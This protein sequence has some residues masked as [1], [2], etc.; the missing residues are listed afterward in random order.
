M[1]ANRH[2]ETGGPVPPSAVQS[3]SSLKL[4]LATLGLVSLIGAVFMIQHSYFTP[5]YLRQHHWYAVPTDVGRAVAIFLDS[6]TLMPLAGAV[7]GFF[8]ALFLHSSPGLVAGNMLFLA[9]LGAIVEWRAGSAKMLFIFIAGGVVGEIMPGIVE[10][11]LPYAHAAASYGASPGVFALAGAYLYLWW[12]D[13]RRQGKTRFPLA[14]SVVAFLVLKDV[15]A[16]VLSTP[17]SYAHS[18]HI[19]GLIF[20]VLLAF[21]LNRKTAPALTGKNSFLH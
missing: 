1:A 9:V 13:T 18:S 3:T 16:I 5:D 19:G 7:E 12:T 8:T 4:P 6:G 10:Q 11:V 2:F 14:L 20:G 21:L 15:M 17:D